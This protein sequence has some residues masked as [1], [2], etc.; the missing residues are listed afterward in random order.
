VGRL[1]H[2]TIAAVTICLGVAPGASERHWQTGTCTD[3]S[4]KR[5]LTVGQAAA[6]S[7]PFGPPRP[8]SPPVVPQVVAYVIETQDQRFEVK[9]IHPIGTDTLNLMVGD[10]V[11]FAVTKNTVYIRDAKGHEHRFRVTKKTRKPAHHELNAFVG[12]VGTAGDRNQKHRTL[13]A[14][15]RRT[16]A[17]F[18]HRADPPGHFR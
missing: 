4:V 6:G 2:L 3:A 7:R 12:S 13:S 14:V 18:S 1:P 8:S 15:T 11:T 16:D 5:D 9:D 10:Q 17:R